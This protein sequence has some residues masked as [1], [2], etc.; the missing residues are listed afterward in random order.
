MSGGA[1]VLW[2]LAGFSGLKPKAFSAGAIKH[3]KTRMFKALEFH[4]AAAVGEIFIPCNI[5]V[6]TSPAICHPLST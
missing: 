6:L 5:V 3:G 2:I 1:L 4:G